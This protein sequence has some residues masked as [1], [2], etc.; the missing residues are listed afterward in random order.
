MIKKA[1]DVPKG[2]EV[3]G[4]YYKFSSP[5]G[6]AIPGSEWHQWF[7]SRNLTEAELNDPK[8][9]EISKI[10]KSRCLGEI[11]HRLNQPK[12]Y[13]ICQLFPLK[14]FKTLQAAIDYL[15]KMEGQL[16]FCT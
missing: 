4:P 5:Y 9:S 7:V 8:T 13:V 16:V 3:N 6:V 10:L 14:E 1:I 11:S 15:V 12:R 2:I